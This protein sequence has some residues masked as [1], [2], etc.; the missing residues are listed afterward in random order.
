MVLTTFDNATAHTQNTPMKGNWQCDKR[1]SLQLHIAI[2]EE[3]M[4]ETARSSIF[5]KVII[6]I[7]VQIPFARVTTHT[8]SPALNK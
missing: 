2:P 1:Q 4:K 3:G 5:H 8:F 6:I 7:I